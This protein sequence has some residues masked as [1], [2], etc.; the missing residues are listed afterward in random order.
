MLFKNMYVYV[1]LYLSCSKAAATERDDDDDT[2]SSEDS[3]DTAEVRAM[4]FSNFLPMLLIP[5]YE[6]AHHRRQGE[7]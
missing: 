7:G 4:C 2:A 6:G 1:P 3:E 5:Q